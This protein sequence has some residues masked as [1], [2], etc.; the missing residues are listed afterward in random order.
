MKLGLGTLVAVAASAVFAGAAI[1]AWSTAGSGTAGASA[2][3]MPTGNTPSVSASGSSVSV[4]WTA[5]TLAGGTAV[6][7]YVI[8]RYDAATGAPATVGAGC[9]GTVTTTTCTETSVPSGTWVYT[10]TPVQD[11]WTG[12]ESPQSPPVTS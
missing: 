1:A 10:D 3:T 5:A 2:T 11:S 6:A 7:G 12:A 9:S 8:H 4:R